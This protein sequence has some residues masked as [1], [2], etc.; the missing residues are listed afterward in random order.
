M[1]GVPRTA[2]KADQIT[3]SKKQHAAVLISTSPP[4][5]PLPPFSRVN[6]TQIEG[7]GVHFNAARTL[8]C[9]RFSWIKA[10]H[11]LPPIRLFLSL[12]RRI[13]LTPRNSQFNTNMNSKC[14]KFHTAPNANP[15]HPFFPQRNRTAAPSVHV[16]RAVDFRQIRRLTTA[17]QHNSS[18]GATVN[19]PR[20]PLSRTRIQISA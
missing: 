16:Y 4:H 15:E 19:G 6:Q 18:T 14:G 12:Y 20:L 10:D 9:N 3:A 8:G 13:R 1:N 5:E 7:T 11:R 2:Y 17:C